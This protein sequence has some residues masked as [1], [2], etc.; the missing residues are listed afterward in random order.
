VSTSTAVE[1]IMMMM[2]AYREKS[3][4]DILQVISGG[5]EPESGRVSFS[6][7]KMAM[8]HDM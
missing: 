8:N 1:V 4:K 3:L 2:I 7:F 5:P 6:L